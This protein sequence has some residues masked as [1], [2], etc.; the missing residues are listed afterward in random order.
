M[1]EEQQQLLHQFILIDM[2]HRSLMSDKEQI[3]KYPD[4]FKTE[5]LQ[6]VINKL[7]DAI[8]HDYYN[9][10]RLLRL[11][12]IQVGGWKRVD[13]E[14]SNYLYTM[15]GIEGVL[16]YNNKQLKNEVENMLTQKF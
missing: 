12:K 16:K 3:E 11:N 6:D 7:L 10:Q 1:T 5:K 15:Q 9:L 2:A 14:H 4:R 8:H 13:D